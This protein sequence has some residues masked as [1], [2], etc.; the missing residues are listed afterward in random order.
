M[1][2]KISKFGFLIIFLLLL[3]SCANMPFYHKYF[4]R[5]Q[6]VKVDGDSAVLCIGSEGG[7]IKGQ[8]LSVYRIIYPANVEPG[9]EAEEGNDNFRREYV[10][11]LTVVAIIDTH[12]AKASLDEGD[13]REHD[14]VEFKQ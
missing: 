9:A 1:T 5:G 13:I 14:V 10:G 7:A 3:S 12:F 6:V 2:N 11:E 4:M 8:T